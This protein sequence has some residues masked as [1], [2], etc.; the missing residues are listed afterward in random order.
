MTEGHERREDVVASLDRRFS[1]HEVVCAER[2]GNICRAADVTQQGL[3][4]LKALVMK[5][6][7]WLI[8]GMVSI[9]GVLCWKVL[10]L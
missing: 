9:I 8:A 6:A 10:G 1:M 7:A 5:V 3:A 2:Y 4:D